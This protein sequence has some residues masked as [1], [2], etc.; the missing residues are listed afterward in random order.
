[1]QKIERELGE[2][3]LLYR[4]RRDDGLPGHDS[5]F[6]LCGFWMV[7]NLAKAG[8]GERARERFEK[9]C[10]FANDVGLMSEQIDSES[11]E[12][13]G[14]FPQGFSHV[15]LIRA[16]IALRDAQQAGE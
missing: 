6:T 15:G 3:G 11:G 1:M 7:M 10:R 9:L 16:A 2:N 4:Y 8:E 14:N 5:T 13:R 12:L